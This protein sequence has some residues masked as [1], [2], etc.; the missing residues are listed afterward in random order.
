MNQCVMTI[1]NY[2]NALDSNYFHKTII[3]QK[4]EVL[5]TWAIGLSIYLAMA[6]R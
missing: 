3:L 4:L 5:Q 2:N 1:I 6:Q